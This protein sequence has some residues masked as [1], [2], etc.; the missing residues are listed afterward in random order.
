MAANIACAFVACGGSVGDAISTDAGADDGRQCPS[1][2]AAGSQSGVCVPIDA[3]MDA[4]APIDSSQDATS[5]AG[6]DAGSDASHDAAQESLGDASDSADTVGDAPIDGNDAA[7]AEADAPPSIATSVAGGE[8]HTC[9]LLATGGVKCWGWN[10]VNQL[11][12]GTSTG[13][14]SPTQVYGLQSGVSAISAFSYHTCALLKGGAL[15]CWGENLYGQLGNG[16]TDGGTTPSL[17]SSLQSGVTAISAGGAHTCAL[18][19]GGAVECWGHN[20][21]GEIGDGTTSDRLMPTPVSGLQTGVVSISAGHDHNC[22]VLA[23]GA[24]E[25]WG[26]NSAGQLGDGSTTDRGMP[27]PVSGL[28]SG[29]TAV[30]SGMDQTC[31]LTVGG[32]L[33]C[34]GSNYFGQLGDGTTTDHLVPTPVTGLQS[35]V[36][37][38]VAG[39]GYTC[40]ILASGAASCWGYNWLGQLGDGTTTDRH[41]QTAVSGLTSG[42]AKIA[43][44]TSGTY[45]V[46]TCAVSIGGSLA[47]WGL[48]LHGELGSTTTTPCSGFAYPC[49]TVP[50]PVPGL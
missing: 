43:M 18:I 13:R 24:L 2:N 19:S 27:T 4:T 49:S 37:A 14:A 41:T 42:V 6:T 47:C 17:V 8:Q 15:Q 28:Q 23:G 38:V 3:G 44:N 22:A 12:D 50:L 20:W 39:A 32:A 45:Q 26:S 48:N 36:T 34:W 29:V 10:S 16:T 9:A 21:K 31:A 30:A 46:H 11:G 25:C 1:P 5:E 35:G 40:A 7:D 33:L